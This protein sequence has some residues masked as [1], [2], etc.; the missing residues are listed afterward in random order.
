MHTLA[1]QY[2]SPPWALF[3]YAGGAKWKPLVCLFCFPVGIERRFG[4]SI[5][6][7][8]STPLVFPVVSSEQEWSSLF[9]L[10]LWV[11]ETQG[12]SGWS[13]VLCSETASLLEDDPQ[14]THSV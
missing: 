3:S 5:D 1:H 11:L 13:R 4:H 12:M 2:A 6:F 10:K 14:L 8:S 7:P 9:L